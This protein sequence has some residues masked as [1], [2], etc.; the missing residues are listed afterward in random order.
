MKSFF[1]SFFLI[2]SAI[3][4]SQSMYDICPLKVGA[5]IPEVQV[6]DQQSKSHEL[7]SIIGDQPSVIIFYRGAWCGYCTKHLAELN[8]VKADIEAMGYQVFGVTIDQAEKLQET[9]DKTEAKIP[10]YSDSKAEVIKAFGLDWRLED[11]KFNLYKEKYQLDLEEWS[12]E[13][14]HNLPVPAIYVIKDGIVQFQYVNPK[15]SVR[16]KPETLLSVLKTI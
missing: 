5:E 1:L 3:G 14:H 11:D 2:L 15:Y 7:K 12:G 6:A 4:F 9:Y 16:L 8:D 10:V 13:S